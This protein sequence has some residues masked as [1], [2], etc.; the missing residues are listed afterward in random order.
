MSAGVPRSDVDLFSDDMLDDPWDTHRRL[1]DMGPV[2]YVEP[3]DAYAISRYADLRVALREWETFSSAEGIGFNNLMNMSLKGTIL[4]SDPPEHTAQ[5]SVMLERLNL[6]E[7]RG[8]TADVEEKADALVSELVERG[9]FDAASDLARAFPARVAGRLIGLSDDVLD[10]IVDAGD[11]SFTVV[12]PLND[13][14]LAGF[15]TVLAVLEVMACLEKEDLAPGSMGRAIYEAADR[16][17]IPKE[18]G[19]QL[20]WNYTGPAFDTTINGIT[21]L[22]W[23][24]GTHPD[25]WEQLRTDRSL[26]TGAV[27]EMLRIESPIQTWGRLCRIDGVV[28]GSPIPAGQRVV[29]LLGSGNR[30][31]RHYPDPDRFDIHRNPT[32]HLAFGHGIHLCV[33]AG[34]S[35]LEIESVLGAMV[36]HITR[37]ELGEPVRRLNNTVRGFSSL[38]MTLR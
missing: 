7:V 16:G 19:F 5:R 23:L 12:G 17:D 34:L 21:S 18:M 11:A 37:F 13:R 25:Q 3:L 29:L 1:R 31:E 32:D 4:A 2:V 14:T 35:R 6:K 15:D 20:L 22:I 26:I 28:D 33:G 8:L 36:K 38:P 27:N 9:S 30:D 24:L 10:Q